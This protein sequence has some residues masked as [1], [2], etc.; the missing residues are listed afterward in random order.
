MLTTIGKF[1]V[2][3]GFKDNEVRDI[4]AP[5]AMSP[6]RSLFLIL[7]PLNFFINSIPTVGSN[8]PKTIIL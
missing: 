3:C 8:N 2:Y 1:F 6:E 5:I 7:Y 4:I